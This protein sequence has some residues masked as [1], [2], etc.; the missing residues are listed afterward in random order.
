[1]SVQ[2][3]DVSKLAAYAEKYRAELIGLAV[4]GTADFQKHFNLIPGIADKFIMTHMQ[5]KKLLKPYKTDWNPNADKATLVPRTLRVEV[6]QVELEEEPEAYRKTFLAERLKPGASGATQHPFE[7]FFLEQIMLRIAHDL[8]MDTLF[9]GVKNSNGTLPKDV[10]DGF[11]KIIDTEITAGNISTARG[12]M[13]GTGSIT[14]SN[15]VSKLKT[16]YRSIA[17]EWRSAML[18]LYISHDIYDK[19]CDD[20]QAQNNSLPYN[21]AFNKTFLEGSNQMCELVPL[22]SMRDSQRLIL[23]PQWNMAIG[24]DTM[25]A[26]EE[27]LVRQGNNPKTLQFFAKL[28]FG[29]QIQSLRAMWVNELSTGSGPSGSGSAAI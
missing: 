20:Y 26:Q 6:G 7:Q 19:Y 5:M 27:V 14:N 4:T 2:S 24:V 29:V 8:N 10:N 18:K 15:A 3:T 23:A 9:Y 11:H 22:S 17:K 13:I 16:F 25:S 21:T 1:M 28:A 12:N